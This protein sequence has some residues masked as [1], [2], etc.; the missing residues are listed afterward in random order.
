M[1]NRRVDNTAGKTGRKTEQEEYREA[2]NVKRAGRKYHK[3]RTNERD[4]E[5]GSS[6]H[7]NKDIYLH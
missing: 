3:K 6:R 5:Y 7:R 1:K 2:V 4:R